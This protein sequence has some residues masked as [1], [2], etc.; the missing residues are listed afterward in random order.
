MVSLSQK[1]LIIVITGVVLVAV[2]AALVVLNVRGG[3]GG[4]GAPSVTLSVWGTDPLDPWSALIDS[5]RAYRPNASVNYRQVNPANY[6]DALLNALAA[7]EG[8][9]V[10]FIGNHDLLS[11]INKIIPANPRQID[12]LR[13]RELYPAAV[14]QDF[15]YRGQI[16][17]LPLYMDTMVMLYNRDLLDQAGVAVPPKDWDEFLRVVPQLRRLGVAGAIERAAAA[18]GGSERSVDSGVDLLNLLMLQN[19]TTMTNEDMNGAAFASGPSGLAGYRAFDFYVQFAN[20]SSP[21]F[22][23][24]DSQTNS[25]E[26]FARGKVAIIFNYLSSLPTIK[27]IS[28]FLRIGTSPM[29][30]P[31]GAEVEISYARYEGL[32]VSRQSK[33][34]NWAWDFVVYASTNGNAAK[35]YAASTGRLPAL[36]ALIAEKLNDVNLSVFARQILTARSWLYPAGNVNDIL[37]RAIQSVLT[38]QSNT[39]QALKQAEGQVSQLYPR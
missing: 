34:S 31:K 39:N 36:R 33:S 17:A 16:Y 24:N 35:A 19:G 32:A 29:L 15:Y 18:I 22:T 12:L 26:A 37:S 2:G 28:P 21:Y 6:K 20:S 9:D 3:G 27:N 10:F 5:Y 1:Q 11:E 13:L 4:G 38:G 25:L 14:E 7:G 23:W 30:Q 8:P